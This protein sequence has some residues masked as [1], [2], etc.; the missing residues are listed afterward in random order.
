MEIKM[1]L[2][3]LGSV[4]RSSL[5]TSE[6]IW[7]ARSSYRDNWSLANLVFQMNLRMKNG[8]QVL[9]G[10]LPALCWWRCYNPCVGEMAFIC[11]TLLLFYRIAIMYT[12]CAALFMFSAALLLVARGRQRCWVVLKHPGWIIAGHQHRW[13]YKDETEIPRSTAALLLCK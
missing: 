13:W 1:W 5:N 2:A 11:Y 12:S 7:D 9:V 10:S 8:P 6:M 4:L 3:L